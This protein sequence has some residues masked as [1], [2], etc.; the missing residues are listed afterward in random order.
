VKA[1]GI[2]AIAIDSAP[3]ITAAAND[4]G[5][6]SSFSAAILRLSDADDTVIGI[7][8]SGNSENV[9][10]PCKYTKARFMALLGSGG[11]KLGACP[12]VK[13]K[14]VVRSVDMQII[15]DTHLAICHMIVRQIAEGRESD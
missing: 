5:Y 15:E 2:R 3:L 4:I 13:D 14:I 10:L 12:E 9:I 8:G 7:S 6:Q 1:A 11:G